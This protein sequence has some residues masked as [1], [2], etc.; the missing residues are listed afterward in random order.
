ME[1]RTEGSPPREASVWF[2]EGS[3]LQPSGPQ[4]LR[5]VPT[6][7]WLCPANWG[8]SGFWAFRASDPS[9]S[10]LAASD[11]RTEGPEFPPRPPLRGPE[12]ALGALW[13]PAPGPAEGSPGCRRSWQWSREAPRAGQ[14]CRDTFGGG[15]G[16][17]LKEG[18]GPV[19]LLWAA[20]L[21]LCWQP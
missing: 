16:L 1:V 11:M 7:L 8:S 19:S 18:G 4:G 17:Y 15:A 13:S 14:G 12:T 9:R 6:D 3:P 10:P 2:W 20:V 5:P 21:P